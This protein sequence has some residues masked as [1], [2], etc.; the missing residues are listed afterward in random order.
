MIYNQ[1]VMNTITHDAFKEIDIRVGRVIRA[2]SFP[3][4]HKPAIKLWLDL[5][6]LGIKQSSAQLTQRY[7]HHDLVG[8]QLLAVVNLPP[9]QIADF[10]S[11]VLVLGVVN[12][13]NDVI[14]VTPDQTANLGNRVL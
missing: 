10:I 14:L 8:R 3:K 11:E 9:R 13:E 7:Q 2:E 5:G 6:A 1:D 4:A 12:D